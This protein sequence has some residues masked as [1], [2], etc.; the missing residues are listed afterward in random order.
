MLGWGSTYGAGRGRSAG[1]ASGQ[2]GRR[3]RLHHL[4]PLPS[5][6]GEAVRS[7]PKVL[8]PEAN[9]GRL[10]KIIRAE[11]LVDAQSYAKVEGLRSCRGARR[12]DRGEAVA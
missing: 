11:F 2:E 10:V 6:T 8:V 5:N 12:G 9:T 7:Y 3:A 4:D 1:A